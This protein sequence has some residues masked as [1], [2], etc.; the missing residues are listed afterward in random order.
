MLLPPRSPT[1]HKKSFGFSRYKKSVRP[2]LLIE[3]QALEK[4]LTEMSRETN[5]PRCRIYLTGYSMGY[6]H[7]DIQT[8]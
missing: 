1:R 4:P 8:E 5:T 6:T 2:V 3:N 7:S